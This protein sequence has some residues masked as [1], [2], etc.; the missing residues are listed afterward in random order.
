MSRLV[1]PD[2]ATIL[3]VGSAVVHEH[4][5]QPMG[6][7]AATTVQ[8]LAQVELGTDRQWKGQDELT[9]R[10]A[11]GTIIFDAPP[12]APSGAAAGYT[13]ARG[14]RLITVDEWNETETS[15][16]IGLYL[17]DVVTDA[18]GGVLRCGLSSREPERAAA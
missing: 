14:D 4:T 5:R 6:R 11:A 2:V 1:L 7:R 10:N 13:P 3:P 12:L 16:T 17:E 9:R 8:V 18:A 15:E